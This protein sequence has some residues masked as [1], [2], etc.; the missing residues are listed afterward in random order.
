MST[1][2]YKVKDITLADYGRKEIEIA[3]VSA[4]CIYLFLFIL[5]VSS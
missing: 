1:G 2:D 3:E 4:I 5:N